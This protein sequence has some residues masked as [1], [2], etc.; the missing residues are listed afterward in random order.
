M[1]RH[2]VQIGEL[3]RI[4]PADDIINIYTVDLRKNGIFF[5][6]EMK[7]FCEKIFRVES[8]DQQ[9]ICLEDPI[10]NKAEIRNWVWVWEWLDF[11]RDDIIDYNKIYG[12]D[13]KLNKEIV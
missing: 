4:K 13:E 7:K 11:L 9:R 6:S 3:V 12:I 1:E 10:K 8:V 2:T 5:N